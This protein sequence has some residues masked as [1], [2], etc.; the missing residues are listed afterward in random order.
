MTAILCSGRVTFIQALQGLENNVVT[1]YA[2]IVKDTRHKQALPLGIELAAERAFA[3]WSMAHVEGEALSDE[4][5]AK[6]ASAAQVKRTS[7]E[8][9][10][11]LQTTL[12]GLRKA[13]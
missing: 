5:H 13:T 9:A 10:K 3:H 1:L 2:R 4:V 7:T 6:P 11:L 12:F 8:Q